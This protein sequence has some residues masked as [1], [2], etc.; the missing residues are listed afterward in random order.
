MASGASVGNTAT[1]WSAGKRSRR[2]RKFRTRRGGDPFFNRREEIP[3]G[4]VVSE[5]A[6]GKYQGL[7]R[8]TNF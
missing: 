2:G 7:G 5:V 6:R 4:L 3:G 8:V 1:N